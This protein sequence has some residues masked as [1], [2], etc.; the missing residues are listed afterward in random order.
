MSGAVFVAFDALAVATQSSMKEAA[1]RA[2][3]K[4]SVLVAP[5]VTV[6]RISRAAASPKTA[7]APIEIVAISAKM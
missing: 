3:T 6:G 2:A 7:K 5:A 1:Q 4:L